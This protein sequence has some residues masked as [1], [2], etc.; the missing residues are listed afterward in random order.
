[1]CF[2][3]SMTKL[4]VMPGLFD[5]RLSTASRPAYPGDDRHSYA[6]PGYLYLR[7]GINGVM[8]KHD[9]QILADEVSRLLRSGPSFHALPG[10]C[11]SSAAQYSI[12][13][14]SVL[15]SSGIMRSLGATVKMWSST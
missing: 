3:F 2:Y 9:V 10:D 8:T 1:M 13:N 7:D 6:R 11:E 15:C 14:M 4:L 5:S 12:E